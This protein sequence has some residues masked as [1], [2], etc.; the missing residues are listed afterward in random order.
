MIGVFTILISVKI[1]EFVL[2]YLTTPEKKLNIK[3]HIKFE[4]K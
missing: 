4:N 3:M 2:K 1:M